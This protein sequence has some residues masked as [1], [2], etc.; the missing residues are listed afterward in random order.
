MPTRNKGLSSY[1]TVTKGISSCHAYLWFPAHHPP[2]CGRGGQFH[3]STTSGTGSKTCG[4][5]RTDLKLHAQ[6]YNMVS[7][8]PVRLLE[9][10]VKLAGHAVLTWNYMHSYTTWSVP[11]QYYFWNGK[12]NFRA[13]PYWPTNTIIH[14]YNTCSVP[15]RY[16]FWNGK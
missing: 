9:W 12:L 4:P 11:H 3:T 13:S 7:S 6:L 16:D 14:S 1:S 10:E 8:T 15:H 5:R 2:W